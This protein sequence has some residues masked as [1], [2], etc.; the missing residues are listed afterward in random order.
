M[1]NFGVILV[2]KPV[3]ITSFDVIRKLRKITGIKKIG[4][5]GTLDPF[6]SGLLP[7]CIG[8]ATRLAEKLTFSSKEYI[9]TMQFGR[10]TETG[11]TEGEV[12]DEADTAIFT[13]NL[14]NET[15]SKILKLETQ[16][17]PKYSAIR[18][19]GRRAYELARKNKEVKLQ[20]RPINIHEFEIL[21]YHHPKLKYRTI[22]SKGTYIRV[23]SETIAELLG[24]IGTTIELRRSKIGEMSIQQSIPLDEITETNWQQNMLSLPQVFPDFPKAVVNDLAT[25]KNG[26]FVEIIQDDL[27]EVMAVDSE[28]NCVGMAYIKDGLLK[29]K[30]VF[31]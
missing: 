22:V 21:G 17:P 25:F 6:A 5:T 13:L 20:P 28:G 26:G 29:P 15:V 18:I 19:N 3:G 31:I 16:T 27:A 10:K 4:H 8:K 14:L 30:L 12:V 2:D 23:L 1:Q 9:V 7:I 11:D 24:T